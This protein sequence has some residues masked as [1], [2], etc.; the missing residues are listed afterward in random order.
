MTLLTATLLLAAACTTTTEPQVVDGNTVTDTFDVTLTASPLNACAASADGTARVAAVSLRGASRLIVQVTPSTSL[1][2]RPPGVCDSVSG[3]CGHLVVKVDDEPE[4]ILLSSL[5]VEI[6]LASLGVHTF[7]VSLVDD[8]GAPVYTPAL[9]PVA[10]PLITVEV[11]DAGA[12]G[13]P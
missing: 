4:P 7:Q 12:D 13:C 6:P 9:T 5:V 10:T 1:T 8:L 3:A 11:V 2:L